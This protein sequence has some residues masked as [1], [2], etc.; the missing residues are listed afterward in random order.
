M[1]VIEINNKDDLTKLKGIG[2]HSLASVHH[3]QESFQQPAL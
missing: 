2:S 1:L 3:N